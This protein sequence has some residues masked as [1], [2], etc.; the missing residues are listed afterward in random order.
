MSR[1]E[2]PSEHL[3]RMSERFDPERRFWRWLVAQV[4]LLAIG[5]ALLGALVLI[6]WL[7]R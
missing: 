3:S 2:T 6:G 1:R 5:V 7:Y 4:A